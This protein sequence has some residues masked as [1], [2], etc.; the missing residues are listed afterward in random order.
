M[1]FN[2]NSIPLIF[3]YLTVSFLVYNSLENGFFWDTVQLASEH[4]NFYYSNNFS[5]FLLPTGIDSGHIPTFGIYIAVL[6]KIFGKSLLVSHL[7]ILPFALGI[8]FELE[9][10]IRKFID[11]NYI[12]IVTFLIV[13]DSTI[14]SQVSLV[15]PDI[16][17]TFFFLLTLNSIFENKKKL[18]TIG[19]IFLFLTSMRGMMIGF[20]LFLFESI[21]LYSKEDNFKNYIKSSFLNSLKYIPALL[22]FLIFN[23]YHY[24]KKGWIGF[25]DNSPWKECFESVDLKG[26][27]KNIIIY[28]WRIVDFGRIGVI[29]L[30]L[31]GLIKLNFKLSEKQK[32]IFI[33]VIIF[34]LIFPL[35]MIWAKNLLAHR[36]LIPIYLLI[37]FFTASLLFSPDKINALNKYIVFIWFTSI[38]TGYLW[39][40][41]KPLT[42]GWDSTVSHLPYYNLRNKAIEYL[43]NEKINF[44][45]VKTFFPNYY[46]INEIDLINDNRHF[47]NFVLSEKPKYIFYSTVFNID[48]NEYYYIQKNYYTK[49]TFENNRIKVSILERKS[50]L[51]NP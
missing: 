45:D 24:Y 35:N 28:G 29:I 6:W 39:I 38:T 14:L 46:P 4:A 22:I 18:V 21:N 25:H 41:P 12:G 30:L 1:K 49:K 9:K 43:E 11:I 7:G 16:P 20:C 34:T 42:Q 48:D 26:F 5:F 13:L 8:V 19:V 17:L 51:N 2:L 40:Y 31:F 10:I 32:Q 44:E 15:S 23:S 36:Y 47:G 50:T 33:L 27:F 3:S 37:S